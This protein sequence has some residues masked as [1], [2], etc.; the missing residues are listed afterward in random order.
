MTPAGEDDGWEASAEAWIAAVGERGDWGRR[1]VLDAPMMARATA[2]PARR[3]LDL[4][5]GEG[6]FSRMLAARGIAAVGVDPVEALVAQAR[7]LHPEGDY[8]IG[9]AEAL[10]F[11]DRAFDLVV[12]YLTLID[13]PDIAR[14][15]PEM[16]RVLAPGGALLIANL[17][18]F[19]TADPTLGRPGEEAT[20]PPFAID[21]YMEERA[22]AVEWDGIRVRN[23]HRPLSAY[24]AR[25]LD[26]GLRLEHF[27][28]PV[29]RGPFPTPE[30]RARA[31]RYRR[32]PWFLIM[33]WSK[34]L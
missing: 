32:A 17:T 10:E 13:I 33:E 1:A 8:R 29:P 27:S 34:P 18:S 16:A 14:A 3:A 7:R 20:G 19:K 4:G 2:R 9:R 22:E 21:R 11:P 15:I 5:C 26:A 28:E 6:R 12:S 24:M 25:L 30:E 23:W 31:E